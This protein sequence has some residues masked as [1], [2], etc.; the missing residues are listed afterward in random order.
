MIKAKTLMALAMAA[1]LITSCDLLNCTPVE[2]K[3]LQIDLY[4]GN[5]E[6]TTI[7][8]TLTIKACG[9]D[10]IL[11]NRSLNTKTISLPLSYHAPVDTFILVNYG[12]GYSM[13][14]TLFVAK[15]NNL[16]FESPDCPTVMMHTILSSYCTNVFIDSLRIM[17]SKV[18][19]NEATHLRLFIRQ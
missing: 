1:T 19:F 8:D 12:E 6:A 9:T 15:T 10:S 14:D 16:Y 7:P 18:N 13:Q 2:V 11:L 4:D 5:G 3:C 17:E